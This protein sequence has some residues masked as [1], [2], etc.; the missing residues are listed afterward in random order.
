MSTPNSPRVVLDLRN[1]YDSLR[2][3]SNEYLIA[4][5]SSNFRRISVQLRGEP[6]P[7]KKAVLPDIPAERV[8]F[9][10]LNK[11]QLF[12]RLRAAWKLRAICQAEQ[13]DLVIAHR[14][15]SH[16]VM[17]L[18]H[19]LY[20][21][22]ASVAVVHGMNQL[23]STWR[24]IFTRRF[25]RH[26]TLVGVSKAVASNIRGALN[27]HDQSLTS[28]SPRV[29]ALHNTMDVAAAAANL[30][31]AD[32]ARHQ[33]GLA[34]DETIIG[35]VARLSNSKDQFTLLR[36]FAVAREHIP[37]ARLVIIGDG[38]QRHKLEELT[39]ELGI[40][41]AVT[42]TGWLHDAGQLMPAFD[43]FALT[44]VEE[45]FGMVLVE[46]MIARVPLVVTDA[47]GIGEVVSG[48]VPLC[49]SGDVKQI[50]D[51]MVR[52]TKLDATQRKQLSDQLFER[53]ETEFSRAAMRRRLNELLGSILP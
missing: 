49:Q 4:L 8:I 39:A 14:F 42:F 34:Q 21:H 26:A 9:L 37:K 28:A 38:P 24:R 30:L 13:V 16:E 18:A 17:G 25:L 53:A 32:Q 52:V 20:P 1:G 44:S 27:L 41:D 36:A 33:L 15:K 43:L 3:V 5:E 11:K 45:G 6:P 19:L 12:W 50:A 2:Q 48:M 7:S 47:G 46:A 31:P 29:V 51:E 23:S 10:G 22:F 40:G 35:H